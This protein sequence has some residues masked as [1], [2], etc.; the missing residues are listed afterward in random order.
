MHV[1][2]LLSVIMV[3]CR[4]SVDMR[5]VI[6]RRDFVH[7]SSPLSHGLQNHFVQVSVFLNFLNFI[8][9]S[10]RSPRFQNSPLIHNVYDRDL[11]FR[12]IL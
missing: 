7:V 11:M 4:V 12:L 10:D 8:Q 1:G 2:H 6:L 3:S 9:I 5:D